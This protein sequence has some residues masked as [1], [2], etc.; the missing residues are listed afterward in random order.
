M[1]QKLAELRAKEQAA[2]RVAEVRV[3]AQSLVP[4]SYVVPEHSRDILATDFEA[5][6]RLDA[7]TDLLCLLQ[8]LIGGQLFAGCINYCA[9]L[10]SSL[11]LPGL[12]DV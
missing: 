1:Q 11:I 7:I 8:A 4:S 12:R 9:V 3:L 10:E 6:V 2:V 5:M